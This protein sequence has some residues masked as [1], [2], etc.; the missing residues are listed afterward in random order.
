MIRDGDAVAFKLLYLRYFSK[1]CKSGFQKIQNEKIVEEIVQDIFFDLWRKRQ[2][3]DANQEIAAFLN[4][5]LRNKILHEWRANSI[6]TKHV[7]LY[8]QLNNSIIDESLSEMHSA[9]EIQE[10]LAIAISNLSPQ[11]R[12][13]FELSRYEDLSYRE[14]S[15]RMA[16]SVKTVEKHIG[17][18]LKILKLQFKEHNIGQNTPKN[19][20]DPS[21]HI[22]IALQTD[23]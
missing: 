12:Q 20:S 11:C 18:A 17:K 5:L 8:S 21:R 22:Y 19:R 10:K 13:A 2:E 16:I 23:E 9:R 15:E 1:L 14:I 7:A 6:R 4:A 3:L